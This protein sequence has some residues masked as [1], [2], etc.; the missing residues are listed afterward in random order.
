VG[1]ESESAE[2]EQQQQREY[3]Q[4]G[5]LLGPVCLPDRSPAEALCKPGRDNPENP[6]ADD[7]NLETCQSPEGATW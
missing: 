1:D 2:D 6:I 3:E 5:D 7:L 4:H